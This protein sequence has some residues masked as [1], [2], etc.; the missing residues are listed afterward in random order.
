M[1]TTTSYKG[2]VKGSTVILEEQAKL[3]DGTEVLVTPLEMVK[4][5]PQAVLAALE[6]SPRVTHEEAAELRR[7]IAEGKRPVRYHTPFIRDKKKGKRSVPTYLLD[8]TTFSFLMEQHPQVIARVTSMA[9]S[10]RLVICTIVRGEIC[11]GLE[12]MPQ[13]RRR[14]HMEATA[15]NLFA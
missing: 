5:S 2:I 10:D 13:G 7:L 9:P 3:P 15:A 14:Q 8:T 6:T 11:Y 1:P 12:R 4:G